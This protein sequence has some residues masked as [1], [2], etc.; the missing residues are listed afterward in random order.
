M[1]ATN[2]V[3]AIILRERDPNLK[4]EPTGWVVLP[5]RQ[6]RV[7]EIL[8]VLIY[9]VGLEYAC[10]FAHMLSGKYNV[11]LVEELGTSNRPI[12]ISVHTPASDY[13]PR[14]NKAKISLKI[15]RNCGLAL[16]S[17]PH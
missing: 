10:N 14:L 17:R 3:S 1:E 15:E 5:V 7:R 6:T 16:L 4:G 12:S 13:S 9:E 8:A 11:K 2:K